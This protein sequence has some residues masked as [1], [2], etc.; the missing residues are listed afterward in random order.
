MQ[1]LYKNIQ[2]D[3]NFDID[4]CK[5]FVS[6]YVF[7]ILVLLRIT[8]T[9][10]KSRIEV[11]IETDLKRYLSS[12][13]RGI[14]KESLRTDR[15][16]FIAESAHPSQLG[17]PLTHKNI[18]TDFSEA[19][20]ELVTDCHESTSEVMQQLNDLHKI[21]YASIQNELLWPNS[22]PCMLPKES[23]IK[24]GNYG[25]SNIGMMKQI[26]RRGLSNRYGSYMQ[27][28]SGIH[29]N[30]SLPDIFFSEIQ[31][32]ENR[33]EN[34]QSFKSD[35]YF[36]LI[37]NFHRLSWFLLYFLGASPVVSK[38]FLKSE[39]HRLIPMRENADSF[40]SPNATSLRMGDLGYKSQAQDSLE[41]RYDNIETY[42]S[43]LRSALALKYSDYEKIG[44]RGIDGEYKQLNTNL[45]Q[46]ENEFYSTI[47]PKRTTELGETP[48][49]ALENRGVEYVEIR[50]I[51][52]NPFL[53]CGIDENTVHLLDIFLTY[54]LLS[55]S[56]PI[57]DDEKQEIPS[58][59]LKTVY[60][61]RDPSL[62]LSV[63]GK[64]VNLRDLAKTL[65][66]DLTP[67]AECLDIANKNT[68]YSSALITCEQRLE[69]D[70]LL[71]AAKI[72]SKIRDTG[73]S[74][75]E[76]TLKSAQD[77]SEHFAAMPM[78]HDLIGHYSNAAL[79]SIKKQNTLEQSDTLSFEEF[80]A[81]FS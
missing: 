37:R 22:M 70:S 7:K 66:N 53:P 6:S 69:N 47:R 49:Q 54:C 71:P 57:S 36:G 55:K 15:N 4:I 23:K 51:D 30:F 61:G 26:Y 16:G 62:M 39:N 67:V 13:R 25:S 19:L 46:I 27:T 14:E 28:I 56:P 2:H 48:T 33:S 58:N 75:Q 81:L 18:T 38:K 1:D 74:F 42:I 43:D 59:Y 65:I 24:I 73:K 9:L 41:I 72:I 64:D 34:L 80:V 76:V 3:N 79:E 77:Y 68:V 44:V 45:L 50:C 32:A 60:D 78:D 63:S 10:N 40:F 52:V 12:I 20:I 31:K 21:T 8:I 29:Y 5:M 11:L 17:S 35:C